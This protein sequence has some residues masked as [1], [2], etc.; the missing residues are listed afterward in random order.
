MTQ[1]TDKALN[2]VRRA[3]GKLDETEP[4]AFDEVFKAITEYGAAWYEAGNDE[5]QS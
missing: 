5:G 2:D 3:L 4:H 1:R